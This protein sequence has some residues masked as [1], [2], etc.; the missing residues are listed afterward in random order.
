MTRTL[1]GRYVQ[2]GNSGCDT[3]EALS[4]LCSHIQCVDLLG[5]GSFGMVGKWCK[6]DKNGDVVKVSHNHTAFHASSDTN[7]GTGAC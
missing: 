4:N 2:S 6:F 7:N 3:R 1:L 5:K